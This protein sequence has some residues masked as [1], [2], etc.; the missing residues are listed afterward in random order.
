MQRNKKEVTRKEERKKKKK[1]ERMN[2]L[3]LPCEIGTPAF[4]VITWESNTWYIKPR[5][6]IRHV[7]F[8]LTDLPDFGKKVFLTEEEAQAAVIAAK[9]RLKL[10]EEE[11]GNETA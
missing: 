5:C 10:I 3:K 6:Y 1:K 7:K 9:I 2:I 11:N 4:R 8:K